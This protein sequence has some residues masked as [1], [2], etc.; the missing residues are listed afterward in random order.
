MVQ[1]S[2]NFDELRLILKFPG[3]G[4]ILWGLDQYLIAIEN[5]LFHLQAQYIIRLKARLKKEHRWMHPEDIEQA[6]YEVLHLTEELFPR[7][8][9]GS[10]LVAL[11]AAYES[12]VTDMADY[13]KSEYKQPFGLDELRGGDFLAQAEK[14]YDRVLGLSLFSN[15]EDRKRI[16]ILKG[17]RNAIAHD[18][19][20]INGLPKE[21][22]KKIIMKT[23]MKEYGIDVRDEFIIPTE[24]GLRQYFVTVKHCLEETYKQV[25]SVL[26][27]KVRR[28]KQ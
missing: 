13:A 23:N 14:F 21:L 8:L 20:H 2:D 22:H 10:Y 27:P 19:G 7:L 3:P 11:W 28:V 5:Q 18:N 12:K 16:E 6:E 26:H 9:R 25:F 15:R 1:K 17:I 4:V 24:T